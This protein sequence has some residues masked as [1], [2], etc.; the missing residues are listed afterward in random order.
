MNVFPKY[1]FLISKYKKK[2]KKKKGKRE[3]KCIKGK[4]NKMGGTT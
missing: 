1:L 3:G 4:T 2:K